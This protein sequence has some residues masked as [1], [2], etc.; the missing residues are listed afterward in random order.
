VKEVKEEKFPDADH[1]YSMPQEEA[2]KL[3]AALSSERSR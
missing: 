2:Q 3:Q 1:S